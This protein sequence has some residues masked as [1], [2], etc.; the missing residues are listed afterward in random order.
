M[1]LIRKKGYSIVELAI[2]VAVMGVIASLAVPKMH[3]Y[4]Q[5]Q[6]LHG[7][8][9][10]ISGFLKVARYRAIS[11]KV[12]HGIYFDAINHT[13]QIV[14]DPLN[15]FEPVGAVQTLHTADR[16]ILDNIN[17]DIG[18]VFTPRGNVRPETL[19]EWDNYQSQITLY[20][21][22]YFPEK[23]EHLFVLATT[24]VVKWQSEK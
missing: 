19:L 14:R 18:V 8:T 5:K 17:S 3:N 2:V 1:R 6:R 10:S 22:R 13:Y 12:D 20:N 9:R 23:K 15:T 16:F 24:G 21:V 4:I 7:D 11:E